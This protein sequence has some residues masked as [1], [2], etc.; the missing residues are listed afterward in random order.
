M[1]S[2][3]L[4]CQHILAAMSYNSYISAI[5]LRIYV[6][7]GDICAIKLPNIFCIDCICA[8]NAPFTELKNRRTKSTYLFF[9]LPRKTF[10]ICT[11]PANSF[12]Y[13]R[14]LATILCLMPVFITFIPQL[15]PLYSHPVYGFVWRCR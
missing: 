12:L 2:F 5:K 9:K 14:R 6:Q 13:S 7:I 10:G 3:Y 15:P 4:F 8:I 11:L 1:H